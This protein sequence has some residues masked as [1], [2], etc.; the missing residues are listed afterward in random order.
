MT[1]NVQL[2]K[3]WPLEPGLKGLSPP[4]Y[5][6]TSLVP[7]TPGFMDIDTAKE[8]EKAGKVQVMAGKSWKDLKEPRTEPTKVAPPK[9]EPVVERKVEYKTAETT[10]THEDK[11]ESE[12]KAEYRT[13]DMKPAKSEDEDKDA[14]A[15]RTTDIK[16]EKRRGR[17]PKQGN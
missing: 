15:Y 11:R 8:A 6:E 4:D 7:G 17:K 3:V 5:S 10:P 14:N 2:A 1:K 16:P 12:D 13:A 9:P